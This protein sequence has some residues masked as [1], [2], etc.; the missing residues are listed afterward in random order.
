M[1]VSLE[2]VAPMSPTRSQKSRPP[3]HSAVNFLRGRGYK[4]SVR[5]RPTHCHRPVTPGSA[6]AQAGGAELGGSRSA[7]PGGGST[8]LPTPESPIDTGLIF[9][10]SGRE[11]NR[12]KHPCEWAGR[13]ADGAHIWNPLPHTHCAHVTG[14]DGELALRRPGWDAR[15][16]LPQDR[17][18]GDQVLV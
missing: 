18:G 2:P 1:A 5:L 8:P 15:K 17:S 10:E 11:G 4:L 14:G 3:S 12:Q 9:R 6:E 13:S 16:L 7:D